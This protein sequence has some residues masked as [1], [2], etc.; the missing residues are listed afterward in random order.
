MIIVAGLKLVKL[1]QTSAFGCLK[2]WDLVSKREKEIAK[3]TFFR[4]LQVNIFFLK[5]R[6]PFLDLHHT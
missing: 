4:N 6:N 3:S 5:I 1:S 2:N